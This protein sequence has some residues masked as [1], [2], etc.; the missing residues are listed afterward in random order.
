MAPCSGSGDA[1]FPRAGTGG[2]VTLYRHI[3]AS[4]DPGSFPPV[5]PD[6][7]GGGIGKARLSSIQHLLSAY[8]IPSSVVNA[9]NMLVKKTGKTPAFSEL[10]L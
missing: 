3:L 6:L 1:A 2:S 5:P 4:P 7:L 9:Q 8:Y 10:V